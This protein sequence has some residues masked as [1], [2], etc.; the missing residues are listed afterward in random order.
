MFKNFY[1]IGPR[2]NNQQ[3]ECLMDIHE[4]EILGGPPITI[5]TIKN[6]KALVKLG[7]ITTC[8]FTSRGKELQCFTITEDGRAYLSGITRE[9]KV[10]K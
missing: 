10:N 7:L 6:V 5:R 4:N 8:H 9:Q 1:F 2:L 3:L